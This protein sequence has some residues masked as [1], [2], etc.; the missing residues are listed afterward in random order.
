MISVGVVFTFGV[1]V[2]SWDRLGLLD[3]EKLIYQELL[4]AGAVDE[5]VW[6][7]YG[8]SDSGYENKL[9]K[10]IRVVPM[11]GIF[12]GF[13]GCFLYSFL[14]PWLRFKHFKRLS[15]IKTNQ[16]RGAWSAW[17]AAKLFKKPLLV[18]TGYTWSIFSRRKKKLLSM[19]LF[20]GLVERCVYKAADAAIVASQD[21]AGYI[22]KRYA[23]NQEK[24]TVIGN[25]VD[26]RIFKPRPEISRYQDRVVFVG[27]LN[28]QKNLKELIRAFSGLPYSLDVYYNDDCLLDELK[29]LSG[30]IGAKVNFIGTVDNSRLSEVL[31]QYEVF[32]LPS[33]Y[34]GMPKAMLE[35][36]ACGLAVLGT[37]VTGIKELIKHGVNGWLVQGLDAG[38]IRQGLARLMS[39]ADLRAKL[40][41]A[42]SEF[43][44]KNFSLDITAQ[45]EA[46]VYRGLLNNYERSDSRDTREKNPRLSVVMSVYNGSATLDAAVE[47]VLNQN[48]RDFEFIIVND[49]STDDSAKLLNAWAAKDK[50]IR[51]VEQVNSGLTKA[52]NRAIA[53]AKGEYIARKDAD[54]T[55]LPGRLA[56]QVSRLDSGYDF[57]CCRARDNSGG[58]AHPK[59]ISIYLYRL[60]MPHK[61]VFIHGT[62]CFRKKVWE[63]LGGYDESMVY[64]Q[65]YDF[66]ARLIL[67]GY[68]IKYL[69]EVFYAYNKSEA[70]VSINNLEGQK[71]CF[72]AARDRHFARVVDGSIED[73]R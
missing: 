11:P 56:A 46:G 72:R 43:I 31:N 32:V 67:G 62:Y 44:D 18:R 29:V 48:Y 24:I 7:T 22:Q 41:G 60:L 37:P 39:D 5:V 73:R 27:R 1:S 63:D 51:I 30:K 49:G 38:A 40:G 12:F 59:I 6:F 47:S 66:A 2:K 13:F 58:K 65:D 10:G 45:K 57:C 25:F 55:S 33:L 34:E 20:S 69:P 35:A 68:R 17:L 42:A 70:C 23:I 16:M 15:I 19:D 54:D 9:A 14:M 4:T 28:A 26:R 3:R 53:L 21:D 36:M 61:N 71:I 8:R 50:R 52:L 64:A